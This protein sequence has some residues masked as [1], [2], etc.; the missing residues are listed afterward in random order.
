MGA[1]S[2]WIG[3]SH[4]PTGALLDASTKRDTSSAIVTRSSRADRSHSSVAFLIQHLSLAFHLS[5][6]HAISFQKC[7]V[8]RGGVD[9]KI[10]GGRSVQ[11]PGVD[12]PLVCTEHPVS[13]RPLPSF[14]RPAQPVGQCRCRALGSPRR[15]FPAKPLSRD[16]RL[17]IEQQCRPLEA[18]PSSTKDQEVGC[19]IQTTGLS[20]PFCIRCPASRS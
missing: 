1:I 11:D 7:L 19:A 18:S 10:K 8:H 9:D 4:S 15:D 3:G 20:V 16:P 6:K 14:H 17:V 2:S 13:V 12:G 5:G